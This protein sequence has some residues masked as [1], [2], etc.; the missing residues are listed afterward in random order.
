MSKPAAGVKRIVMIGDPHC[1]H[2]AGLTPP[3]W[4][5]REGSSEHVWQKFTK[6]QR[7]SWSRYA[8][9]IKA[10]RPITCLVVN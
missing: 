7:E 9:I 3:N 5:F 10:L 1:G 6:V 8:K 4:R 2:R